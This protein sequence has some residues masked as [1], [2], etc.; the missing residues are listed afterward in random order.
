MFAIFN[1]F[2]KE[3]NTKPREM[4]PSLSAVNYNQLSDYCSRIIPDILLYSSRCAQKDLLYASRCAVPAYNARSITTDSRG[5][6]G[7]HSLLKRKCSRGAVSTVNHP[8][9]NLINGTASVSL[10]S[11]M[12]AREILHSNTHCLQKLF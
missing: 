2:L 6:N 7:V 3:K 11:A 8:A 10:N 1:C 12:L 5:V 4:F 9:S